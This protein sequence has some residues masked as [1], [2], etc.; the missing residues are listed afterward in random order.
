MAMN[1]V[2]KEPI[3]K[4]A[5][6]TVIQV[7]VELSQERMLIFNPQCK[8]QNMKNININRQMTIFIHLHSNVL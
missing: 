7:C 1:I 8:R 2:P 6:T 4:I 5:N 3:N